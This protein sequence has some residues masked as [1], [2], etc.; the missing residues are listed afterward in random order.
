MMNQLESETHSFITRIWLE[1]KNE[2]LDYI[3]WRG[4]ITH[5]P[6]G[7]RL[8]FQ[9][10]DTMLAFVKSHLKWS[11]DQSNSKLA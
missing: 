2:K 5:I 6:S 11:A 4:H 9:D 10:L 8:Y 1:E 7:K 3:L